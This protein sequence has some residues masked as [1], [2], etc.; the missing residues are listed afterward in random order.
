MT[1]ASKFPHLKRKLARRILYL[2]ISKVCS[3]VQLLQISFPEVSLHTFKSKFMQIM[4]CNWASSFPSKIF[5]SSHLDHHPICQVLKPRPHI[6]AIKWNTNHQQSASFLAALP[7]C[8]HQVA[9][10]DI[11]DWDLDSD[12]V[13]SMASQRRVLTTSDQSEA[14]SSPCLSWHAGCDTCHV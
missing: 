4:N 10:I 5:M 2:Q 7:A 6:F 13:S 8:P 9:L 3:K 11:W 1:P 14:G 12:G